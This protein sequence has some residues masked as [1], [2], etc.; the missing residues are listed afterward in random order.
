MR[1]VGSD[2]EMVIEAVTDV[3]FGRINPTQARLKTSH[4]Y[5]VRRNE[6][7]H[8]PQRDFTW[9]NITNRYLFFQGPQFRHELRPC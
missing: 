2:A 3:E 6:R 4:T 7:T 5:R 8:A 9:G 1:P